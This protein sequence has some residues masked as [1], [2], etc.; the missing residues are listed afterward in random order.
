V[1][2]KEDVM[3]RSENVPRVGRRSV[4]AGVAGSLGAAAALPGTAAQAMP[5]ETA[6]TVAGPRGRY[7]SNWPDPEP[8]GIADT[9]PDLWPRE[10]NS[11]V[12]PLEL[13]PRDEEQGRVW[14][15]DTYVNCFDVDGRPVY[16]ATGTSRVPG[17]EAAAPWNDGIF[18]W[19]SPSLQGP[20]RL[21]DTTGIRPGAEKGKVW[22]PEFIDENTAD[23]VVVTDW[24][25]YQNP[26]DPATKAGD[27]WAPELHYI[28]GKWYLVACMGDHSTLTGS[29][30]LV[31]DGGPEGPYRNIEANIDHPLGEPVRANNP[32]YYHI[33]G[34]L[35]D[36]GDKTYLVLHN[37]LYSAMTPDME[38]LVDPTNLPTF[39]QRK[40]A[41][42]PYLEGANVTKVG[43]KYYLMHAA[44]SW[45]PTPS[46]A[47]TY[48][49][50]TGLRQQYDAV[51]AVSDSFEGPYTARYTAGVGAGH[52]NMFVD[53]HGDV[54][55]TFFRNP[56]QGYWADP[57]RIADAAVPGVVRVERSGP[58]GEV[59]AVA[60]PADG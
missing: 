23:R 9:R 10:D 20:W 55:M 41:P 4:L 16:V 37:D 14:M 49:S 39:T 54:W 18:V 27:V 52:N 38:N 40:Y 45:K 35:F 56:A 36:D 53:E 1:P 11:F 32:Q 6:S 44:W 22:S 26:Q 5:R 29:F 33:D 7:P 48:L 25:A 58:L 57:S 31:S 3:T 8:Y 60:R 47:P 43:D 2:M 19:V 28:D 42:E 17:L 34:G 51:V 12:L 30:I 24:Q 21:A 13:R 46:A 50:G 15:R 59:L